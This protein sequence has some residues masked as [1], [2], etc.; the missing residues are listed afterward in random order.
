MGNKSITVICRE[1]YRIFFPL[2]ILFGMAGV[3]HWLFYPIGLLKHYSGFYHS[4]VQIM[5]YMTCFVTGFLLTAMPRFS[6]SFPASRCELAGF[7]VIIISIF[8]LLNVGAWIA[9]E[10]FFIGW[11]LAIGRFAVVR[12][13]RKTDTPSTPPFQ[14]IWIPLAILH[15]CIGSLLLILGQTKIIPGLVINVGKPML[16]QGF[17]LCIVMGIGGFLIPRLMGTFRAETA[18]KTCEME[19]RGF[20]HKQ[21]LLPHLMMG[22][23]LFVSFWLEG[24]G[25][26]VWGYGLRAAVVSCEFVWN[27][28]LP[29]PP[30]M[31][32]LFIRLVWVSVWM[33]AFG[34]WLAAFFPD[35][36]AA[37]LH[38]V[39][40]GGFSLMT[41]SIATMV[42][43][44]HAGEAEIL[45]RPLWI[46][47][48]VALGLLLVLI[49]RAAVIFFPN[50]YFSILGTAA[51]IWIIVGVSWL[52]S[53]TPRILKIP[54]TDEFERMHEEAK[55]R[56]VN[57]R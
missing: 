15:G 21:A 51:F 24:F 29:R 46:L 42:I 27:G 3:G 14:M 10:L 45:R 55:K 31:P 35:Y 30:K 52:C 54:S 41:F 16:E 8:V 6:S 13:L 18:E 47:W 1:P 48:I 7:L 23:L 2:G 32:E 43:M 40:I 19:G 33:I 20:F 50:G 26:I 37:F 56:I 22:G 36:R 4:C 11:L 38:F 12:F 57:A 44:S 28:L 9:A 25:K 49:E 5:S 34:L 17:L 39:F 53:M